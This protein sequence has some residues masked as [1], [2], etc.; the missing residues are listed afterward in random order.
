MIKLI[1]W[2]IVCFLS[3]LGFSYVYFKFSDKSSKLSLKAKIVFITG[4]LV[5]TILE[6]FELNIVTTI[7]FFVYYPL[8]FYLINPVPLKKLIY[9]VII[10]WLYA[11]LFDLF[12]MNLVS[13]LD[14]M[15]IINLDNNWFYASSFLTVIT[16]LVMLSIGKNEKIKGFT[17]NTYL[18][19]TKI[20]YSD[21]SLVAFTILTFV[22]AFVVLSSLPNVSISLLF[23]LLILLVII[24][25][26]LLIKFKINEAENT[27]YL[28]TLKENN[29]F[30]MKV[31]DENRI[32]K[33]NLAAK[34]LSI[35][36]VSNKKGM[37]LIEDLL[38]QFNKNISFS[39]GLKVIPYGLN[40]IIYQKL[41]THLK[42][43]NLQ[44]INDI[45]YDIFDFLKPRRYN[46]SVEKLIIALDNAIESALVSNE[47]IIIIH[48]Y[49]EK[50]TI[51]I[52]I[53]NTYSNHLNI[54]SLGKKEYSTKGIHRGIGLFSSLRDNEASISFKIFNGIFITKITAKKNY[55]K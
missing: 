40:G 45:N 52:E 14:H 34:L 38:A 9:Y 15:N 2:F 48:L 25:F 24:V 30:Y 20:K 51:N 47:K 33:H 19:L 1:I 8:L 39:D 7:L 11:T 6:Y 37:L 5:V 36:S 29:E 35:K 22:S 42:K 43:I 53:K 46:V 3:T 54:D 13:F 27:K 50:D 26:I 12:S 32:F 18:W 31:D 23:I 49:D 17:N 16:F 41:Y 28:Q 21:F 44:I 10:I 4:I 55:N